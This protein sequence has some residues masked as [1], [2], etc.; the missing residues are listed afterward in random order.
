M[1]GWRKGKTPRYLAHK[2]QV[3]ASIDRLVSYL[4]LPA[5]G[6]HKHAGA[7]PGGSK[8]SLPGGFQHE[9]GARQVQGD[10]VNCCVGV[11]P[12][13]LPSMQHDCAAHL[14]YHVIQMQA[15]Q[16]VHKPWWAIL[17]KGTYLACSTARYILMKMSVS[18]CKHRGIVHAQLNYLQV[19]ILHAC[20]VPLIHSLL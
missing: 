7:L 8:D 10:I 3:A 20:Y 17:K 2:R 5:C 6:I 13:Q 16:G 14:V 1:Q 19:H 9:E 4:R 11:L 15:L 12:Q 18:R